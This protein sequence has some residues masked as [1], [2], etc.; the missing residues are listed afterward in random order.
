[1]AS[2]EAK[3]QAWLT[4]DER[5]IVRAHL[6]TEYAGVFGPSEI[7]FHL[8]AHV[9]GGF[10]DYAC[11]VVSAATPAGARLLDVG[12]GYGSFVMLARE[13]GFD[14]VG[15][16]IAAFEIEF[17]R[18]RLSRMRP[19]DDPGEVFLD[20][21]IFNRALD[22]RRFE[23][24]TFWNVLEHV[25]HIRPLMRRAAE[26]LASGGGLYVVCPNY[27]AWRKEAHYQVPWRPF[28]TRAAAV[29]RLR[30]H[31][32]DPAF[33]SSAVFPRT[34]WGVMRELSRNGLR[35]FDRMNQV[36]LH[37]CGPALRALLTDPAMALQFYNPIRPAVELAARKP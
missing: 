33:F 11:Q 12:A 25:E 32:K 21:G 36:P 17:S 1:L 19:H 8:D 15:T 31:G 27:A 4:P 34:S 2:A 7:E 28:L 30:S 20:G 22:G 16:E 13:R 24:I 6:E 9:G 29:R 14:A 37:P 5:R 18:R 10:A 23:A 26:L 35:L 3:D